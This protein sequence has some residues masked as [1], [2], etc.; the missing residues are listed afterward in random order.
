MQ[1]IDRLIVYVEGIPA[2]GKTTTI[3]CLSNKF[4]NRVYGVPEYVNKEEVGT[5]QSY[6][7]K[8][9]EMKWQMAKDSDRELTFVDRG[10]LSTVIYSLAESKIRQSQDMSRVLDWYFERVLSQGKLPDYY[11]FLET[12]PKLSL[13]RRKYLLTPDNVWD[14]QEALEFANAY[15]PELIKAYESTIPLLI[16]PASSLSLDQLEQKFISHFGL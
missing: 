13:E 10:H 6:F 15:Y 8:N 11:V 7:M 4:P 3:N 2:S 5:D 16:I 9:D 14:Y 12:D 1:K